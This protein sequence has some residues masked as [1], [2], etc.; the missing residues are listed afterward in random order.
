MIRRPK[1]VMICTAL[2]QS[3]KPGVKEGSEFSSAL[4]LIY[5]PTYISQSPK[6]QFIVEESKN[7]IKTPKA[8]SPTILSPQSSLHHSS[9]YYLGNFSDITKTFKSEKK[10][11]RKLRNTPK[12]EEPHEKIKIAE[13]L[14]KNLSNTLQEISSLHLSDN[15]INKLKKKFLVLETEEKYIKKQTISPVN[16][17]TEENPI[18]KPNYKNLALLK[19]ED[20]LLS[21]NQNVYHDDENLEKKDQNTIKIDYFDEIAKL[22]MQIDDI[23]EQKNISEEM[24]LSEMIVLRKKIKEGEALKVKYEDLVVEVEALKVKYENCLKTTSDNERKYMNEMKK[25]KKELKETLDKYH[26]ANLELAATN[27]FIRKSTSMKK[28]KDELVDQL[29]KEAFNL[30]EINRSYISDICSLKT[31]LKSCQTDLDLEKQKVFSLENTQNDLLAFKDSYLSLEATLNDT[32][33]ALNLLNSDYQLLQSAYLKYQKQTIETEVSLK[34]QVLKLTKQLESRPFSPPSSPTIKKELKRFKTLTSKSPDSIGCDMTHKLTRKITML[35]EE[36]NSTQHFNEKTYKDLAYNRKVIEEKNFLISQLE[37]KIET[38]MSEKENE[39]RK[40]V[41][42]D[43]VKFLKDYGEELENTV[44][45]IQCN[46]CM[47]TSTRTFTFSC[48]LPLCKRLMNVEQI[49]PNCGKQVKTRKIHLFKE[50]RREFKTLF[51][52]R[53]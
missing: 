8:T 38:C 16:L 21:D 28:E 14:Y 22:K 42:E 47:N 12:P 11:I 33:N 5:T 46:A 2:S 29:R 13:N 40:N 9:S 6:S 18:I 41:I 26:D 53:N 19:K 32:K 36:I 4:P 27:N 48:D 52:I 3:P 31:Q 23:N 1:N 20:L 49:C 37:K 50:L 7:S 10:P 24:Y 17:E 43:M 44:D 35:E 39:T 34:S 45:V 25:C 15:D 30:S 51:L